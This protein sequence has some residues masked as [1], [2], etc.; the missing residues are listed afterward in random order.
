MDIKP[1]KRLKTVSLKEHITMSEIL[2]KLLVQV[3]EYF[4]IYSY[5]KYTQF[6]FTKP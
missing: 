1:R 2:P 4:M 6:I 3:N 5:Q